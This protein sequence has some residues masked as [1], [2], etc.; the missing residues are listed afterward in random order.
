MSK[1]GFKGFAKSVKLDAADVDAAAQNVA[2]DE[3]V[4]WTGGQYHR[5][6]NSGRSQA[7]STIKE[8]KTPVPVSE[9][10]RRAA[11]VRQDG[12]G[13]KPN[14]VTGGLSLHQVAKP[15]VYLYLVMDADGNLRARKDIPTPDPT[16]S[17]AAI[18][19]GDIVIPATSAPKSKSKAVTKSK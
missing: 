14:L 19:A 5:R 7:L 15:A 11:S 17:T 16:I 3:Y 10:I 4:Y 1:V 9:L 6:R 2:A 12:T 18:K 13:F 8:V